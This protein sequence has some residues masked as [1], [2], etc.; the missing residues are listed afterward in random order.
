MFDF[1]LQSKKGDVIGFVGPNGSGKTTI[2]RMISGLIKPDSGVG[3]CLGYDIQTEGEKIRFKL[4]YMP[5]T[6]S[7]YNYLT[8]GEN[9]A[10]IAKLYRIKNPDDRINYIANR[11]D[12]KGSINKMAGNLSIGW[13]QRLSLAAS[14]LHEPEI[15]FLDEPTAGVDPNIKLYFW[16]LIKEIADSGTTVLVSTH[17][18]KELERCNILVYLVYGHILIQGHLADILKTVNICVWVVSG[19]GIHS[20]IKE[21]LGLE[22]IDII[23]EYGASLRII[24]RDALQLFNTLRPWILKLSYY[25]KA[26]AP[27]LE[28]ILISKIST[29]KDK[30]YD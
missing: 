28:D 20:L 4:G 22:G 26:V 11:L 21:L 12:L 19:D 15:L 5:Q 24:G 23:T 14:L 16:K 13:K 17:D 30:R 27:T 2:M 9:L 3:K 29:I 7:L 10:F 1:S 6:F 18:V 25:W 8:I